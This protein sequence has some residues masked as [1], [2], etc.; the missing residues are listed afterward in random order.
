MMETPPESENSGSS[1]MSGL[2]AFYMKPG[3][4]CAR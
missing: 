4:L 2:E 1:V 3:T